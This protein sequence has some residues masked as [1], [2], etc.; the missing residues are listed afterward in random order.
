VLTTVVGSGTVGAQDSVRPLTATLNGPYALAWGAHTGTLYW[1]DSSGHRVRAMAPNGTV[2]T[3]AGTGVQASVNGVRAGASFSWP[4]GLTATPDES[5]IFVADN[6]AHRIRVIWMPVG[7]T[8]T[9]AGSGVV[10]AADG[11][12]AAATFNWPSTCALSPD[13]S[14]LYVADSG[15]HKIRT[16]ATGSGLAA[17]FAGSGAAG[18]LDGAGGSASFNYPRSI[19]LAPGGGT[20]Y[21]SERDGHRVRAVDTGASFVYTLAGGGVAGYQDGVGAGA[22]FNQPLGMAFT[23]GGATLLV[24]DY[25]NNRIRSL[26]LDTLDARSRRIVEERWLKVNDDNSGG[27]TLHDL[28]DEYGVSA[29]RIRQI[30]VAAMKKMRKALGSAH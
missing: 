28:A 30:E 19:L 27:M 11:C 17:T 24:A 1:T 25:N 7:G 16:V 6:A 23:A 18:G 3:L 22:L 2:W 10:G 14:F 9:L 4:Y 5:R 12:G 21:V 29:E 20:L 15:N 26:A 13:G 8:S